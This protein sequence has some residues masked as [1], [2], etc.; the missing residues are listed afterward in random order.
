MTDIT[1]GSI[2]GSSGA[3]L[4]RAVARL[5]LWQGRYR[6][7]SELARLS[8]RDLRDIGLSPSQ[9]SFE[10]SKPFWRG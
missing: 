7:R 1:L 4:Q 8:P 2:P 6:A 5:R 10:S 3:L 9:A